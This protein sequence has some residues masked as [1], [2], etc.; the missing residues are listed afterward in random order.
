M[1]NDPFN[2]PFKCSFKGK[3]N[4]K[5][6]INKKMELELDSSVLVKKQN[7]ELISINDLKESDRL[8][9]IVS[10]IAPHKVIEI[11]VFPAKELTPEELAQKE[12]RQAQKQAQKQAQRQAKKN[13][14]T[15]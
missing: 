12:S 14:P 5:I 13:Q 2:N 3:F 11:E 1:Q 7:G 10:P 9:I 4:N 6:T 15:P 8:E